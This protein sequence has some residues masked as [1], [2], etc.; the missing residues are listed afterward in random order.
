MRSYT[1]K[2]N[3]IGLA[4]SEILWYWQRSCYFNI[5]IISILFYFDV[6]WFRKETR[7]R[8]ATPSNLNPTNRSYPCGGWSVHGA[9][10]HGAQRSTQLHAHEYGGTWRQTFDWKIRQKVWR[11]GLFRYLLLLSNYIHCSVHI[12]HRLSNYLFN[13]FRVFKS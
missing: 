4:V 7:S 1:L 13:N 8:S 2:E 11:W 6:M 12:L 3:H 10:R 9:H 5:R